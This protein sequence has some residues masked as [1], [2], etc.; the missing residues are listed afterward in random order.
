[1]CNFT[2][3]LSASFAARSFG[4][5]YFDRGVVCKD[6]LGCF[7]AGFGN[8]AVSTSPSDLSARILLTHL[9][10][11]YFAPSPVSATG[12]AVAAELNTWRFRDSFGHSAL[13]LAA[14]LQGSLQTKFYA[15]SCSLAPLVYDVL[16]AHPLVIFALF[17]AASPLCAVKTMQLLEFARAKVTDLR[18]HLLRR[19][20]RRNLAAVRRTNLARCAPSQAD[21]THGRSESATDRAKELEL[22]VEQQVSLLT[23]HSCTLSAA[24]PELPKLAL[25]FRAPW[26]I[27]SRQ[28][29]HQRLPCRLPS[30]HRDASY[31]RAR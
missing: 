25:D 17:T 20:I 8:S 7:T 6:R 28:A 19:S 29:R 3:R 12:V 9:E 5:F 4:S 10:A 23:G 30:G 18:S 24:Q 22:K 27:S 16:M 11:N 26:H 2:H 15:S 14:A 1:M 13:A 31:A 21:H